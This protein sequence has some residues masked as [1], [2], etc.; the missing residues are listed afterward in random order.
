MPTGHGDWRALAIDAALMA[1]P[2]A[3]RLGAGALATANR[4]AALAPEGSELV[5][6]GTHTVA[7]SRSLML[8]AADSWAR[9]ATLARHFADHGADFGAS[10]ADEYARRASLFLQRSQVVVKPHNVV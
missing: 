6:V 1:L 9:P 5:Q 8:S 10:S 7:E 3:G 2:A 4:A